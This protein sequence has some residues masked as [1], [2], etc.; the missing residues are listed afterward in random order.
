MRA[1]REMTV[2]DGASVRTVS[3]MKIQA[4]QHM[5]RYSLPI[6]SVSLP[7]ATLPSRLPA[8]N[9]AV[10]MPVKTGSKPLKAMRNGMNMK[11]EAFANESMRLAA[12]DNTNLL[13]VRIWK[14][15][16]FFSGAGLSALFPYFLKEREKQ[17]RKRRSAAIPYV[18]EVNR[19]DVKLIM[20]DAAA[21]KAIFPMSPVAAN[22]PIFL[23][24]SESEA[25]FATA[26]NATG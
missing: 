11:R 4:S 10:N 2:F 15:I 8:K 26:E 3:A 9:I 22:M 17:N 25:D 7:I 23:P 21:A 5:K 12:F 18:I 16:F 14:S 20:N 6:L 24:R 13:F 1:S 19:H